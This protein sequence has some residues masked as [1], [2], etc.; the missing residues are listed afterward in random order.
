MLFAQLRA[1]EASIPGVR[2]GRDPEKLHEMRVAARRL[3]AALRLFRAVLPRP[4]AEGLRGELKWL[5]GEVA[6]VR[7]LD[8]QTAQLRGNYRPVATCQVL[9][10]EAFLAW[11]T[12]RRASA[13]VRLLS[14]LRSSRCVRLLDAAARIV[15]RIPEEGRGVTRELFPA[16]V[17]SAVRRALRRTARRGRRL[18]RSASTARLHRFRIRCKRVRYLAEFAAEAGVRAASELAG[19]MRSLQDALG[20]H[21]D[22][23]VGQ[24]LLRSFARRGK[25]DRAGLA[26]LAGWYLARA[27][28]SR[29]RFD[30]L[31][32]RLDSKQGRRRLLRL[33]G[34]QAG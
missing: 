22:A 23:V 7:D 28:R 8:V 33:L 24:R 21:Q 4:A 19:A 16:F 26:G 13:R 15:A 31:F 3:R 20:A 1:L 12:R 27:E 6:A 2:S 18:G 14:A 25:T 30:A 17:A 5:A 11:L 29:R 9:A 10:R 34:G 32:G